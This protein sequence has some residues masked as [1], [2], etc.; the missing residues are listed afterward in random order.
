ALLGK[1]FWEYHGFS[2]RPDLSRNRFA[3]VPEDA[4]HL[5]SLEGLSLYHNCLRSLPP[6]IANLQA[7][8]H[9]NVSRNQISALPACLCRLP[10]K[11]LIA[12]NN[13][14]ASLPEDIGSL[15][16]LRQLVS[17]PESG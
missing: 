16:S 11:V 7:L 1:G 5:M 12:S 3:E 8:T 6:A 10:L 17:R 14:L 13:R 9:L 15:G 4:C 2:S